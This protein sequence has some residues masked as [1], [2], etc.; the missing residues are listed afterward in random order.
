MS[1][2]YEPDML[3]VRR[4]LTKAACVRMRVCGLHITDVTPE[5]TK[6]TGAPLV[7]RVD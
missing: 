5:L 7:R 3:F 1:L 6:L 2:R 4:Q